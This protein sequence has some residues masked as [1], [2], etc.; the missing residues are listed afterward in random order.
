M[1]IKNPDTTNPSLRI[2]TTTSAAKDGTS[3]RYRVVHPPRASPTTSHPHGPDGVETGALPIVN[4]FLAA[5]L[6]LLEM[7]PDHSKSTG[8]RSPAYYDLHLD[9]SLVLKKIIFV[10]DL[11][12]KLA[13]LSDG[14]APSGLRKI[15]DPKKCPSIILDSKAKEVLEIPIRKEDNLTEIY[16]ARTGNICAPIAATIVLEGEAWPADVLKWVTETDATRAV[17]DGFLV[18][19]PSKE[20]LDALPSSFRN[21][22]KALA[23][24]HLKRLGVWEFKSLKAAPESFMQGIYAELEGDFPWISCENAVQVGNQI[25]SHSCGA[26][27]SQGKSHLTKMGRLWKGSFRKEEASL[28]GAN[29][30]GLKRKRTAPHTVDT[31]LPGK[32]SASNHRHP[33][34]FHYCRG[35]DFWSSEN[36]KRVYMLQ[37]VWAEAVMN[38][39]TFLVIQAGN[40]EFIGVRAR[41]TQTL[42]LSSLIPVSGETSPP[43]NKVQLGMYI[44]AFAD[45]IQRARKLDEIL[46][47]V[48]ESLLPLYHK[49]YDFDSLRYPGHSN[50]PLTA[51]E[52]K[53]QAAEQARVDKILR[54]CLKHGAEIATNI[55]RPLVAE[56]IEDARL[57]RWQPTK[58]STTLSHMATKDDG[59][60]MEP[61]AISH[62]EL[63]PEESVVLLP[64]GT[65]LVSNG[66]VW[67]A[68]LQIQG[69]TLFKKIRFR[70]VVMKFARS[71]EEWKALQEEYRRYCQLAEDRIP[72]IIQTYGIFYVDSSPTTDFHVL[73]MSNGG[74]SL[75]ENNKKNYHRNSNYGTAY[76]DNIMAALTNMHEEGLL[77]A[78]ALTSDH[79][80]VDTGEDPDD[81]SII[82]LGVVKWRDQKDVPYG[83]EGSTESAL[84]KIREIQRANG[85][86]RDKDLRALEECLK[87]YS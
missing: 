45:A 7:A 52:K 29:T 19:D 85:R 48:D 22:L 32:R 5:Q 61:T 44:A 18:A 36:L 68:R 8:T 77:L 55:R 75:S 86:L 67:R 42:Y 41:E 2:P 17:A 87:P 58:L 62:P 16:A 39:A 64:I 4:E 35:T 34:S 37:Q 14:M 49:D 25:H 53:K 74:V 3:P 30:N 76:G 27:E 38:D 57:I 60:S 81:P 31:T 1:P 80:L 47:L 82:F 69:G 79:I 65:E 71:S 23:D 73:L 24:H 21:D 51:Q 20:T 33:R 50:V 10:D 84:E 6:D 72:N 40:W 59:T 54:Y 15:K 66:R 78:P 56:G 46:S 11:T 12:T 70:E 43:Y 13:S 63:R 83:L 9:E 26:G 28:N